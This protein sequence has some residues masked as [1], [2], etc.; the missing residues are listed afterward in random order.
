MASTA[1]PTYKPTHATSEPNP[2]RQIEKRQ[3]NRTLT[4]FLVNFLALLSFEFLNNSMTLLS[5]G[6]NPAT[7]LMTDRTN[8]VFWEE[9]PLRVDGRAGRS[10][11][12]VGW[13]LLAPM[14]R[15]METREMQ[16]FEGERRNDSQSVC[17]SVTRRYVGVGSL[18][19]AMSSSRS[20]LAF[21]TLGVD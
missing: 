9:T 6:E 21:W 18:V 7:S 8:C 4:L 17:L 2:F 10:R 11:G 19:R 14:L 5:Y 1:E 12:V 3:A 16:K 13:P 15:S 20:C